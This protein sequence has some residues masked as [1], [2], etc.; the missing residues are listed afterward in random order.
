LAIGDALS[1]QPGLDSL[2]QDG[3]AAHASP[4]SIK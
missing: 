3:R 4:K 1:L 2:H